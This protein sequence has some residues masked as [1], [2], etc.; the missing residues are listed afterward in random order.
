MATQKN[1]TT[2][3]AKIAE[4]LKKLQGTTAQREKKKIRKALRNLGHKG[5]LQKAKEVK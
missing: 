5:G 4:L 1:T 2:D 3:K